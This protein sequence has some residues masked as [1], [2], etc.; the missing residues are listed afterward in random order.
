MITNQRFIWAATILDPKPHDNVLEIGCGAGLLV[1]Q[2]ANKL[3]SGH[4]TAIDRSAAMIKMASKRNARSISTGKINFV[5]MNFLNSDFRKHEFD[6]VASFNVNFFWKNP[7]QE[8]KM[9]KKILKPMG[10][11]YIFYQAPFEISIT[12]ANP[13]KENLIKHSFEIIDTIFKKMV[14]TSAFCVKARPKVD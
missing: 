9:I 14:P 2:I 5:T 7:E 11:L 12:A 3:D 6:K 10:E 4:I 1:D 13:V 8:L